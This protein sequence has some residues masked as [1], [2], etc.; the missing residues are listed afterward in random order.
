MKTLLLLLY[1]LNRSNYEKLG[2]RLWTRPVVEVP[3]NPAGATTAAVPFCSGLG[4]QNDLLTTA[5]QMHYCFTMKDCPDLGTLLVN[6]V[7]ATP[8]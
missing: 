3:Q 7:I 4:R 5:F 6:A 1:G 8:I 2:T